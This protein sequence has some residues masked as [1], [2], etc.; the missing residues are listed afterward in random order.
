MSSGLSALPLANL[1]LYWA[2]REDWW[3]ERR[4]LFSSTWTSP[5]RKQPQLPTLYYWSIWSLLSLGWHG[6]GDVTD[7]PIN[8]WSLAGWSVCHHE[9]QQLRPHSLLTCLSD[10]NYL[11]SAQHLARA[12]RTNINEDK[13]TKK[14]K[15]RRSDR[16]NR[17]LARRLYYTWRRKRMKAHV[18]DHARL[19]IARLISNLILLKK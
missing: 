7:W 4:G 13:R 9:R 15:N 10:G 14:K 16:T 1:A 3:S 18:C 8:T 2:F 11:R 5:R 12:D 19:L 6:L 17:L